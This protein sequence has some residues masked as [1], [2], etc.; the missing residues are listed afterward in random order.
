MKQNYKLFLTGLAFAIS[1][2]S[3]NQASARVCVAYSSSGSCLFWTGS[4]EADLNADHVNVKKNPELGVVITPNPA[5]GAAGTGNPS[6]VLLCGTPP[7]PT[8]GG[9]ATT[10]TQPTTS[11]DYDGDCLTDEG[12]SDEGESCNPAIPL[13]TTDPVASVFSKSV[14]LTIANKQGKVFYATVNA[15]ALDFSN[16]T[17]ALQPYCPSNQV[18]LDYVSCNFTAVVQQKQKGK[19]KSSATFNCSLPAADCANLLPNPTDQTKFSRI[20]YTCT[21]VSPETDI[22]DETDND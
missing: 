6:A 3:S 1:M 18:P 14:P 20:P 13:P 10:P 9:T 8:T 4:V 12:E 16:N 17:G 21:R 11:A 15:N 22:D 7:T 19:V 5:T 2:F